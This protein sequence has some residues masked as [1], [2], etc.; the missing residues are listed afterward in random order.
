MVSKCWKQAVLTTPEFWA[1]AKMPGG[2]LDWEGLRLA[3]KNSRDFPLDVTWD[4]DAVNKH[5]YSYSTS[6]YASRKF[7]VALKKHSQRW[8]TLIYAGGPSTAQVA[9]ALQQPLDRLEVAKIKICNRAINGP[10]PPSADMH[11][12]FQM[13]F[14]SV[15]SLRV[16]DL[17][18]MTNAP[19]LDGVAG[20]TS[21]R[22]ARQTLS[23][24]LLL[25]IL[26]NCPRLESLTLDH[27]V[28]VE[29]DSRAPLREIQGVSLPR[30]THLEILQVG[31][32]M[33][34]VLM[35]S[36]LSEGIKQFKLWTRLTEPFLDMDEAEFVS[37]AL[38]STVKHSQQLHMA[39]LA[40]VLEVSTDTLSCPAP[41]EAQP[42]LERAF[43]LRVLAPQHERR[44]LIHVTDFL[45]IAGLDVPIHL[46]IGEAFWIG[47]RIAFPVE[48]LSKFRTL[49]HLI[50]YSS[51]TNVPEI[52]AHLLTPVT[53][54]VTVDSEWICPKL[55]CVTVENRQGWDWELV[56]NF[57]RNRSGDTKRLEITVLPPYPPQDV[58]DSLQLVSNLCIGRDC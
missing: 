12:V 7:M 36:I 50:L 17:E 15:P 48:Q 21:L 8:R 6:Y 58:Q 35:A 42:P 14:G 37:L 56:I 13:D 1:M 53:G 32:D 18:N 46:Q 10:E 16:L 9:Q 44:T 11:R 24:S 31:R 3:L 26:R 38:R 20:L 29:G 22:L 33:S 52:L 19:G 40:G 30:L 41:G 49:V 57:L 23:I 54:S 2:D 27:V 5:T 47:R 28:P 34:S 43:F 39:F 51:V 4:D 45:Q 55:S 25:E